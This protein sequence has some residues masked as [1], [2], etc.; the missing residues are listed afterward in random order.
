MRVNNGMPGHSHDPQKGTGPENG[1]EE[2]EPN[3]VGDKDRLF[4]ITI[5]KQDVNQGGRGRKGGDKGKRASKKE[6]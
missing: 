6:M 1:T 4:I 5:K 2:R 3:T